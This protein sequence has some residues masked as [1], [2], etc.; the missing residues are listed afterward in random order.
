[1]FH[2]DDSRYPY[3][4]NVSTYGG[5]VTAW[6]QHYKLTGA[7]RSARSIIGGR[8]HRVR[9]LMTCRIWDKRTNRLLTVTQAEGLN[10]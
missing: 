7:I 2:P 6:T 1:M 3:A 4:V 9:N 5:Q 8:I 10:E